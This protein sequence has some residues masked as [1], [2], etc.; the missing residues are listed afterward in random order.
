MQVG[1]FIRK[2][3]SFYGKT[4]NADHLEVIE[5]K[6]SGYTDQQRSAIY[7]QLVDDSQY[8]PKAKEILDAADKLGAEREKK[9][10]SKHTWTETDCKL[11]G[12]EGRLIVVFSS[13]MRED[14]SRGLRLERIFPLSSLE[15]CQYGRGPANTFQF[16]YRCNC[17]AGRAETLSRST[18]IWNGQPPRPTV[19][20]D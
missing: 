9:A 17:E 8:L 10:A 16:K 7:Y 13:L 6:L 1:E 5:K 19:R 20:L 2:I 14:H 4:Y 12:G 15:L 3:Q 11:C 18:A